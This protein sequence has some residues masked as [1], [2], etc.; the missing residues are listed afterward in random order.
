MNGEIIEPH[1]DSMPDVP[2]APDKN[3][4]AKSKLDAVLAIIDN[5]QQGDGSTYLEENLID[6]MNGVRVDAEVEGLDR[7]EAIFRAVQGDKNEEDLDRLIEIL[8]VFKTK[9]GEGKENLVSLMIEAFTTSSMLDPDGPA[10]DE[11]FI[12]TLRR[13]KER[14]DALEEEA[15][16]FL[17]KLSQAKER[18]KGITTPEEALAVLQDILTNLEEVGLPKE[19]VESIDDLV[20]YLVG[21]SGDES[22]TGRIGIK[23]SNQPDYDIDF[24]GADYDIDFDDFEDENSSL[25]EKI[26]VKNPT[27]M[28]MFKAQVRHALR[29]GEKKLSSFRTA[30][31]KVFSSANPEQ[32]EADAKFVAAKQEQRKI[33]RDAM[34][35]FLRTAKIFK[36]ENQLRRM[37]DFLWASDT[38]LTNLR[39]KKYALRLASFILFASYRLGF[40]LNDELSNVL[41]E[42]QA[43]GEAFVRQANLG[44]ERLNEAF[45][46]LSREEQDVINRYLQSSRGFF[47]ERLG[48][49]EAAI[50]EPVSEA[51]GDPKTTS[52]PDLD[53]PRETTGE[54]KREDEKKEGGA[55]GR[56]N[57]SEKAKKDSD[58]KDLIEDI[59]ASK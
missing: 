22:P 55:S 29:M 50:I 42:K 17:N 15:N 45:Q 21:K 36:S 1:S 35:E 52:K 9:L 58:D 28:T 41:G 24:D 16:D 34:G 40:G 47:I 20:R 4:D 10:L 3:S 30:F 11:K 39:N 46:K 14:L 5:L 33:D 49:V 2:D 19:L 56:N 57:P 26:G 59:F 8:N 43:A 32:L 6:W 27:K 18:L 38:D 31:R 54:D 12:S 13:A 48:D 53:K 7:F 51:A 44:K 25:L 37:L 23:D